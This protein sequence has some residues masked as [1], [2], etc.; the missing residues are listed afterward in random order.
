MMACSAIQFG[1]VVSGF[2]GRRW[3]LSLT[4]E[5]QEEHKRWYQERRNIFYGSLS[6][7]YLTLLSYYLTHL[8]K[9]PIEKRRRFIMF[10]KDEQAALG[11]TIFKALLEKYKNE[12]IPA[13]DPMYAR[14]RTVINN[15][16]RANK[17]IFERTEWTV[18]VVNVSLPNA[19]VFSGGNVFVFSGIFDVI[20]NDDQLTFILAH[21][22]SHVL[23]LHMAE[24]FSHKVLEEMM[25][26]VPLFLVWAIFSR[27]TALMLQLGSVFLHNILVTYPYKRRLETEA[28]KVGFQLSARSCIDLREVLLFW[29]LM[30]KYEELTKVKDYVIPALMT[31]PDHI[32]RQRKLTCQLP[33]ALKLR[34]QAESKIAG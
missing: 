20:Q 28:D 10:S 26:A 15:I 13:S 7:F 8:E 22:M 21:E 17:N 29:E 23:L 2:Y 5:K 34:D 19:M 3:W 12:L 4:P 30:D 25:Y 9:D 11:H 6:A 18:N 31:H 32:S 24:L 1:A 16:G 33:E 27:W 14:L